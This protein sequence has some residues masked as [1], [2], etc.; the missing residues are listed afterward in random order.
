MI[1]LRIS[2]YRPS[3][4]VSKFLSLTV[5]FLGVIDFKNKQNWFYCLMTLL[6]G[7]RLTNNVGTSNKILPSKQSQYFLPL[8]CFFFC[9]SISLE[10]TSSAWVWLFFCWACTK[11]LW[12]W[13]S[14]S[15]KNICSKDLWN[16]T[17]VSYICSKVLHNGMHSGI[18]LANWKLH[19]KSINLSD[20]SEST[21]S[22]ESSPSFWT[23]HFKK[24]SNPGRVGLNEWL[25]EI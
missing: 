22:L 16:G 1:G 15:L 23:R 25:I 8:W 14:I 6:S 7:Q 4:P 10:N 13:K 3:E 5:V 20:L 21:G 24:V 19:Q 18:L 2:Q 9:R 12:Q 17:L 11:F